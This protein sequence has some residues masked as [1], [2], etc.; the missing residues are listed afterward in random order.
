MPSG[1]S[2]SIGAVVE[3]VVGLGEQEA[4]P[5]GERGRGRLDQRPQELLEPL[6]LGGGQ[7]RR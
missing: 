4:E 7:R 6:D 3:A 5:L 1:S 2:S